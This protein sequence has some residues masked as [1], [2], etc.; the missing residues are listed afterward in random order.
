MTSTRRYLPDELHQ[1][2]NRVSG[3]FWF[4]VED[5]YIQILT[6]SSLKLACEAVSAYHDSICYNIPVDDGFAEETIRMEAAARAHMEAES[7][8]EDEYVTSDE[9]MEYPT[10]VYI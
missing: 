4:K 8:D 10:E 2:C 6:E 7:S 5:K 1:H 3:P 9:D